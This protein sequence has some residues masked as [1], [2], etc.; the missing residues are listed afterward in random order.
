MSNRQHKPRKAN[1]NRSHDV[2]RVSGKYAYSVPAIVT[3]SAQASIALSFSGA[4]SL[5][6]STR[7]S[8]Y[9]SLYA[10]YRVHD[11]KVRFQAPDTGSTG[12]WVA[13]VPGAVSTAPTTYLQAM[14]LDESLTSF[15]AA[16]TPSTFHVSQRSL[17]GVQPWYDCTG[18]ELPGRLYLGTVTSPSCLATATDFMCEIMYDISFK[19]LTQPSVEMVEHR[20]LVQEEKDYKVVP[21]PPPSPVR[22]VRSSRR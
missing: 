11:I 14:E 12:A 17:M 9:P 16:T 1:S 20:R 19:G 3:G 2:I 6:D 18:S 8:V 4:G 15:A 13:F 22:S 7:L 21:E 5:D 10:L